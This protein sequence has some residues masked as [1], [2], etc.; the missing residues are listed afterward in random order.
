[1]GSQAVF[2]LFLCKFRNVLGADIIHHLPV[3][4]LVRMMVSKTTF[5]L[6]TPGFVIAFKI[7]APQYFQVLVGKGIAD[8]LLYCFRNQSLSPEGNTDPVTD[9][10]FCIGQT[11]IAL[12]AALSM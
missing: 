12:F 7:A 3:N 1:M 4:I 6:H 5:F 8:D 2:P 9:F 10:A 11:D